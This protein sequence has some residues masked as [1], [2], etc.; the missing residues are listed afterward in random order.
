MHVLFQ[1]T[2]GCDDPFA[3]IV[4]YIIYKNISGFQEI[5]Q[6]GRTALSRHQKR[7]MRN[8]HWQNKCHICKQSKQEHTL[9]LQQ[10]L[11]Y[12]DL[13]IP[14]ISG[15]KSAVKCIFWKAIKLQVIGLS[16]LNR[17]APTD[18][19]CFYFQPF[20]CITKTHL[21]KFYHKKWI[22]WDEK[23]W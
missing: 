23:F 2:P 22:L 16:L 1:T 8:K 7:E 20:H 14:C 9:E 6:L 21:F 11:Q 4:I 19:A 15:N 17:E 10:V 13:V 12:R 3:L 5:P 18:I